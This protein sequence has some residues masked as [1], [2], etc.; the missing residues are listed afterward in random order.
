MAQIDDLR[1][2]VNEPEGDSKYG[3]AE[4][5]E[6]LLRNSGSLP[7]A[8]AEVWRQK[9]AIA[10]QLVDM[11]E[12]ESRRNLSDLSENALRMADVYQKQADDGS[13]GGRRTAIG[14]IT[15]A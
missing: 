11:Q 12:G 14:R 4:L 13:A 3:D 8:A 2:A 1:R 5:E 10:A 15:R 7:A 6:I 9:A